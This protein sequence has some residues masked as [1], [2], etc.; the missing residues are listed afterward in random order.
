MFSH[1]SIHFAEYKDQPLVASPRRSSLMNSSA[2]FP[3]VLDGM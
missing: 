3:S 1:G 2:S